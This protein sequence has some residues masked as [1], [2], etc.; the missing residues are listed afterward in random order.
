MARLSKPNFISNERY[1]KKHHRESKHTNMHDIF[2]TIDYI[3]SRQT[4]YWRLFEIYL[5]LQLK[6]MQN[7][8][9]IKNLVICKA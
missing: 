3:T 7:A 6:Y 2:F 4:K 8:A 1:C 9:I 5:K